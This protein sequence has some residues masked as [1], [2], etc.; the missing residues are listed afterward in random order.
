MSP[1]VFGWI[2]LAHQVGSVT[3]AYGAG[4]SRNALLSYL[5][6]FFTAAIELCSC[7]DC[8]IDD[9]QAVSRSGTCHPG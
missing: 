5:P 2:S 4:L 6:T 8:N 1:L 9:T 3:A 7:L